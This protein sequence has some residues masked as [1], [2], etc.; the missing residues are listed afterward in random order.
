MGFTVLHKTRLKFDT[1]LNCLEE[2]LHS[3]VNM[4][5]AFGL[6]CLLDKS[7]KDEVLLTASLAR[8][9]HTCFCHRVTTVKQSVVPLAINKTTL[10]LP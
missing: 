4:D 5:R 3:L 6:A 7:L 1:Q 10:R 9:F 8:I 2:T